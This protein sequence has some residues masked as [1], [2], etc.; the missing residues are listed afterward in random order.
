MR[1]W[2]TLPTSLRHVDVGESVSHRL[3][4]VTAP[5]RT[6]CYCLLFIRVCNGGNRKVY[7]RG[8]DGKLLSSYLSSPQNRMIADNVFNPLSPT[9]ASRAR[10]LVTVFFGYTSR[11]RSFRTN[12]WPGTDGFMDFDLSWWSVGGTAGTFLGSFGYQSVPLRWDLRVLPRASEV[13]MC[14]QGYMASF[15]ESLRGSR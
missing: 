7:F 14:M 1:R 9:G 11:N 2:V 5:G 10:P 12:E 15:I 3:D 8:C 6:P 13:R 4:Q